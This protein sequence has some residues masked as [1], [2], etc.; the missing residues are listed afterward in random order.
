MATSRAIVGWSNASMTPFSGF[1]DHRH[2]ISQHHFQLSTLLPIYGTAHQCGTIRFGE[3]PRI[4]V[5]NPWCLAH[6]AD[7]LYVVDG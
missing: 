1:G 5:L 7:N 4:S 2:A 3:D 6:E